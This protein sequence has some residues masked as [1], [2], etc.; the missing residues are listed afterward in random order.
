MKYLATLCSGLRAL[1]IAALAGSPAGAQAQGPADR[2]TA[3]WDAA[4]GEDTVDA[5]Q[6][7]LELFPLGRH[8]GEAFRCIVELTV[9][10]DADS[11]C[12]LAP[13]AGPP[14]S[15]RGLGVDMY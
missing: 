2:E 5:Y 7:Y 14:T 10:P 13:G 1:L 15:S 8:S 11:I 6:R 9:D 12:S 4:R 3:A